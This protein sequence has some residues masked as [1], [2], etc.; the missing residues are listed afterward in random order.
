VIVT[1][2]IDNADRL[3]QE[4]PADLV[5]WTDGDPA[6]NARSAAKAAV[7]RILIPSI[8]CPEV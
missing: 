7:R 3:S 8:A 2:V 5:A 1:P 6:R 4:R